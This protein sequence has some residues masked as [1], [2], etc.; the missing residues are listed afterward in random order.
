MK[1]RERNGYAATHVRY[2]ERFAPASLKPVLGSLGQLG[3]ERYPER[4]APAS[5]KPAGASP[6][7]HVDHALSGAFCSGLIE[8][9]SSWPSYELTVMVLSGAFCSG[10]IE[11][12]KSKKRKHKMAGYPERFAPASLKPACGKAVQTEL[13]GYPERFAPASLKLFIIAL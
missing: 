6:D 4:F 10:L 12:F 1:L 5:L 11:A 2:P 8:A 7:V 13:G 3:Q 9:C